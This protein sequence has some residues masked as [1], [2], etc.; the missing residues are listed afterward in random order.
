[1]G[2]WPADISHWCSR[3]KAVVGVVN[4]SWGGGGGGAVIGRQFAD[5]TSHR[6]FTGPS[7]ST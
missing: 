6:Q 4:F 5:K 1:M 7:S 2:V 3:E